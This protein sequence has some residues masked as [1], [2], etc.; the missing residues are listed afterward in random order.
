V[1]KTELTQET[2]LH[3]YLHHFNHRSDER[4]QEKKKEFLPC[5]TKD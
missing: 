5:W 4:E 3:L 1:D 2:V